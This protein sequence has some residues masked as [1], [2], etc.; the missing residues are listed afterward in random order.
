MRPRS[1]TVAL[2]VSFFVYLI[3]L[4]GPHAA[5]LLG[6]MFFGDMY[7]SRPL[8]FVTDI[9]AGL[10][11][12]LTAF[13]VVYLFL[14]KRNLARGFAL[15]I[16]VPAL[17]VLAQVLFMLWI[18]SMFLI[19]TDTAS[20]TGSWPVECTANDAWIVGVPTAQAPPG[21]SVP[22]VLIQ[23]SKADYGLLSIPG[24]MVTPLAL[25]RPTLQPDGHVDFTLGIDYVVPGSAILFNKQETRTGLQT[26]LIARRGQN[27]FISVEPP[28]DMPRILSSD[29]EWISWI[30]GMQIVIRNIAGVKPEVRVDISAFGPASYV[31]S[32][33]DMRAGEILVSRND[34]F[35]VLGING[36]VRSRIPKPAE[37]ES[38]PSTFRRFGD[39]WI[40]WDAYRDEGRY[41]VAWSL[42]S[43]KGSHHVLKGRSINSVAVSP[44]GDWIAISVATSLNIGNIQDSIYVL[45]VSDGKEVFR[46]YLP[47]YTRT[48][49]LF[50]AK[51]LFMYSTDG[52]TVVLRIR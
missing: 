15:L 3:P 5:P 2:L 25:P 13:T 41:Q 50:P 51:D 38:Q 1:A 34:E 18:P 52:K 42:P 26:W 17:F 46:R 39:G 30:D 40:A 44:A 10:L 32:Y 14:Q 16:T 21:E 33:I 45:R 37:V 47:R 35:I 23:T 49:V 19:E 28:R 48:Q 12:Q 20:D 7:R 31:L 36:E 11:L 22:D 9:A 6:E 4:L 29:G 24:C 8:W 43:G 27:D